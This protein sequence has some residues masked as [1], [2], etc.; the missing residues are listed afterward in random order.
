MQIYLNQYFTWKHSNLNEL[1]VQ[2]LFIRG[3]VKSF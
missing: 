3:E 2:I 1:F